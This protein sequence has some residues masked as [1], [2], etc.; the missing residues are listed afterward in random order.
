MNKKLMRFAAALL[1]AAMLFSFSACR[2][3]DDG[4]E[5]STDEPSVTDAGNIHE[6]STDSAELTTA[7]PT[8]E[9]RTATRSN[10]SGGTKTE[11]VNVYKGLNSTNTSRVLQYYKAAAANTRTIDA[12][13]YMSMKR[14]D[15]TPRNSFQKGMLTVFT[16]IASAALAANSKAVTTIPGKYKQI[17]A[18]D[19]ISANAVAYGNYTI[20]TLNVRMQQDDQNTK[21]AHQGPV[22]RTVGTVG[23]LDRV[24]DEMPSI[25]VDTS[26][27]SITLRYDDCK[28]VVK[29]DNASGMIVSGTWSYTVDIDVDNIYASI[30]GSDSM[31][32]TDTGGAV[33]YVIKTNDGTTLR[34]G[35]KK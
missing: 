34:N 10:V 31:L 11:T 21:D 8:T 17:K 5:S 24:F 2:T 3:N 22:G 30:A 19:L 26:K 27:G 35:V 14:V 13:Q 1:A 23:N 9:S 32:I 25:K 28:V 16:G 6:E 12:T 4:S 7:E 18:S 29:I 33:D 20:V 15:Y